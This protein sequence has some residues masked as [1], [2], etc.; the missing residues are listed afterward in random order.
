MILN[1]HSLSSLSFAINRSINQ[2]FLLIICKIASS[3]ELCWTIRFPFLLLRVQKKAPSS[4][5]H[6]HSLSVQITFS[7]SLR[8]SSSFSILI[9]NLN[10][11]RESLLALSASS[12]PLLKWAALFLLLREARATTGLM[13]NARRRTNTI[14]YLLNPTYWLRVAMC[15]HN[16]KASF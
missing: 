7:Y 8:S 5:A 14:S 15:V 3:S 16:P 6:N 10:L 2:N 11:Q 4:I 9:L 13:G 12:L 1:N